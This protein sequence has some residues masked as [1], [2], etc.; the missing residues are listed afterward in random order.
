MR[1][2]VKKI[3]RLKRVSSD[4]VLLVTIAVFAGGSVVGSLRPTIRRISF[5]EKIVEEGNEHTIRVKRHKWYRRQ[6]PIFRV[7]ESTIPRNDYLLIKRQNAPAH[8]LAYYLAP[9]PIYYYSDTFA[10]ELNRAGLTY[11]VITLSWAEETGLEWAITT[12][13]KP[14]TE[15]S[16]S[17]EDY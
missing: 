13:N 14:K 4:S 10:D 12:W 2:A 7:V 5:W 6:Y 8:F 11:H 17:V 9:R 3:E 15:P 1:S 16:T